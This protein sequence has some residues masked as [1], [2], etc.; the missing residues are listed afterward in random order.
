MQVLSRPLPAA[1]VA[2]LTSL[3]LDMDHIAPPILLYVTNSQPLCTP[4]HP[5]LSSL[6]LPTAPPSSSTPQVTIKFAAAVDMTELLTYVSGR[7]DPHADVPRAAI[8]VLEVV[9]RSGVAGGLWVRGWGTERGV[10]AQEVCEGSLG[11]MVGGVGR[12]TGVCK[13]EAVAR[14]CCCC[15]VILPGTLSTFL[16]FLSTPPAPVPDPGLAPPRPPTPLPTAREDAQTIGNSLYFNRPQDGNLHVQLG[17][18]AEAWAGYKQAVKPCQLGLSFNIDLAAT[19]FMTSG[20][21]PRV[22]VLV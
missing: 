2:T 8:Q 7:A 10:C 9:M 19:A 6:P 11:N 12:G 5:P 3:P 22:G 21:L 15:H 1:P 20:P 16:L 4:S 14:V 13:V 17:A 18:G